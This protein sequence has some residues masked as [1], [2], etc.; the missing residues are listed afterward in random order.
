MTMAGMS[1]LWYLQNSVKEKYTLDILK[2]P[3]QFNDIIIQNFF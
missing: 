3:D 2:D 1:F